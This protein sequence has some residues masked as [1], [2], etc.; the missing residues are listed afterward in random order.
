MTRTARQ[1]RLALDVPFFLSHHWQKRPLLIRNALPDFS[2]PITAAELAGMA[3]EQ[4]VESRIVERTPERW[5]LEHG[6]FTAASYKRQHPWTLLVQHVDKWL[7]EVEALRGCVDFLPAWR[8]DD[9]MV[10][11]AS[12]QGSVGPH[13]DRYDVFLLQGS[14]Y[15]RWCLGEQ[16]DADTPCVTEDGLNL[17]AH[18]TTVEE[19]RLGPGDALYIPP[20]VAHWGMAEGECTTFSLGFRAPPITELLARLTDATLERLQPELLL[21]DRH[22]IESPGRPGELT[23]AHCDNARQAVLNAL[24]AIDD[25]VWL[26]ELLSERCDGLEPASSVLPSC[27][28]LDASGGFLWQEVDNHI[29]LFANGDLLTAPAAAMPLLIALCSGETVSTLDL[30]L[31]TDSCFRQLWQLGVLREA[32]DLS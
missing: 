1:P 16:C 22:S 18:F 7:P 17:L 30:D 5:I 26:G 9:V 28:S 31:V 25:G 8:F 14:G 24:E 10:S 20:G 3:M 32:E 2:P 23:K 6:P 15:R 13:F 12:D 4:E 27:V 11:Y 29:R 19:Y 21:E